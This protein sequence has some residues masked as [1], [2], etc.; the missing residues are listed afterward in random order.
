MMC[1]R[2]I[3]LACKHYGITE[4][5]R[6]TGGR[7][8]PVVYTNIALSK[9]MFSMGFHVNEISDIVGRNRTTIIHYLSTFDDRYKYDSEFRKK[10]E[11]FKNEV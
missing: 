2:L 1:E 9:V 6:A 5:Q 4:E 10:Y 3:S 8:I 11:S 7:R